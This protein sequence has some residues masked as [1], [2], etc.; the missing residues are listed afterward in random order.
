ATALLFETGQAPS[1]LQDEILMSAKAAQSTNKMGDL[2]SFYLDIFTLAR[3]LEW[4]QISEFISVIPN[5]RT[6][7]KLVAP[8][9][10]NEENL[11]V[12]FAAVLITREPIQLAA[13]LDKFS[14]T[15]IRDIKYALKNGS[16]GLMELLKRKE[17]VH[18]P[19]WRNKFTGSGVGEFLYHPLLHL[20]SNTPLI[21]LTLKFELF[22][23]GGFLIA[24]SFHLMREGVQGRSRYTHYPSFGLAR[25]GLFAVLFLMVMLVA[26][27]P[28][29]TQGEQP[30]E[31]PKLWNFSTIVKT[32]S[33]GVKQPPK[34]VMD[35]YTLVALG[36]FLVLQGIIY[37]ICLMKLAE[38]K[39]QALSSSTKL[40]LLENEE[41]LFDSGL[42]VG[43]AGTAASLVLAA[44]KIISP[45]LMAAYSSTL[46]GILCVAILK[47]FHVRPFRKQLI[48]EVEPV[49]K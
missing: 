37:A 5:V 17:Q 46:F 9:R 2:E 38:I 24:R 43:F 7:D 11:P 40:K 47:I 36:L 10:S 22:L 29:L 14:K 12:I 23:L 18:Y 34:A 1:S 8:V 28:Y 35:Q 31:P 41:N 33:S 25:Q 49:T 20:S 32:I 3:R 15:G 21:A 19:K 27:E 6:L 42:Y 48:L 26:G 16:L 13:Y 39:R 30:K 44:F 45:S 4:S